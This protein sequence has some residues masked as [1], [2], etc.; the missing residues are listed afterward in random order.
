MSDIPEIKLVCSEVWGGN[1][2]V[3]ASVA[4]PG[5]NGVVHSVSA[6]GARGGDI[7]YLSAC[8]GG[9][10]SR[11][12]VAD[13]V[14]HG[15]SV[16]QVSD[17]MHQVVRRRMTEPN[18]ALVFDAINAVAYEK[19]FEALTTAVCLSYESTDALMRFCYAGHPLVFHFDTSRRSWNP[20]SIPRQPGSEPANLPFGVAKKPRYDV[21]EQRVSAGD[22]FVVVTDGVLETPDAARQ[23]FGDERL[24]AVLEENAD[25]DQRQFTEAVF[26]ALH[27][28]AGDTSLIHDD[29][30]LVV[31]DV[32]PRVRGPK[33]YHFV[34]NNFRKRFA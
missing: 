27:R 3:H 23:L 17:W 19:G 25:T 30:S 29:V 20:L 12:C 31:L 11:V 16:S 8:M 18:P 32:G 21:G 33:L 4:L 26:D 9:M 15:E 6:N 2:N 14:G 5:M 10:I 22:R 13:V 34:K 28:H 1:Q 7:C 24:R